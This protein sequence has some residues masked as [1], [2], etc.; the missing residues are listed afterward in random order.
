[1]PIGRKLKNNI[2]DNDKC[3]PNCKVKNCQ[4]CNSHEK[5]AGSKKVGSMKK[6]AGSKKINKKEM[7]NKAKISMNI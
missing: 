3:G 7:V 1:M 5:K 6:K 4:K 2:S